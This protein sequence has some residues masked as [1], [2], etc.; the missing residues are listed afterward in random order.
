M[1]GERFIAYVLPAIV[2]L[3]CGQDPA[4]GE[5]VDAST[6]GAS[7]G[8]AS[9]TR[10][11]TTGGGMASSEGM[12]ESGDAPTSGD[13]TESGGTRGSSDGSATDGSATRG[14]A[15]SS[16]TAA[17][18][19]PSGA[20]GEAEL[21]LV[22]NVQSMHQVI[23]G[24]GASDAWSIDPLV[25]TWVGEGLESEVEGLADL[26]FDTHAGI[27]LSAWRFNIGA[28]SAEQGGSSNIS[29]PY[30]RA[31]TLFSSEAEA[32]ADHE[33]QAGQVRMLQEAYERGVVDFVAFS[34]S[35]PTYLT[36][37]GLAHPGNGT[38]QGA[39][40]N[41][42]SASQGASIGS[43]NLCPDKVDAF[44][45][46]LVKVLI[47][48]RQDVGVPVNYVSPVNEPTWDWQGQSQEGN[49]YNV[50]DIKALY[51]SLHEALGAAGLQ[52]VVEIDG[53]E[54]VEYTAALSDAHKA[55]FDGS[56]YSGGMN[57]TGNGSYKNYIDEFLG[58]PSMRAI[59]HDKISLHGYFSDAWADRLGTLRDL[60]WENLQQTSPGSK[61]WMS[62]FCI[63]G[64]AGN[65]RSFE[66]AGWNVDDLDYALHVGKVIHRDLTRLNASAWHW[67][68]AVTPYDYKDGLLKV[69]GGLDASSLQT[70][71]V[72][73]ALGHFS[74]FVRP[75]FRRVD[76]PGHDDW[77]GL[78]ASA[79]VSEDGAS[80]VVV[81]VNASETERLVA[82]DIS[83]GD[84]GDTCFETFTTDATRDLAPTGQAQPGRSYAIP[85]R[86]M[87]TF[88]TGA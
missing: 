39:N 67:W 48:L 2:V 8:G 12:L 20:E 33:K 74:R 56:A 77:D 65:A 1:R 19:E 83:T 82:L 62:E 86:S 34:N 3:A 4:G 21:E 23:D 78:M 50:A 46:F 15:G 16:T 47:H 9:A 63:L 24:F 73:W 66:G 52:E 27:G 29:D 45:D 31:E 43:T 5:A 75:G 59:L 26:L 61:V 80:V 84:E 40:P 55:R 7:T 85:A 38:I 60:T 10:G 81:V 25:K 30:R 22:V 18:C 6:G 41:C 72:L 54:V 70:S 69:N 58:D 44:A 79:Y 71:K 17:I 53:T 64:D 36:K 11:T 68:L 32:S 42:P 37:N 88:R 35:P 87:V 51:G 49:R 13:E 57:G 14:S 28:G 76:L